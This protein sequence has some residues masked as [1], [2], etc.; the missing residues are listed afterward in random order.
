MSN[1]KVALYATDVERLIE[2]LQKCIKGADSL[3]KVTITIGPHEH[4]EKQ[5]L[6]TADR[7][8]YTSNIYT[9]Q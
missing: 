5:L 3:D 7:Q 6:I 2:Q 8:A 9:P 1:L 4:N